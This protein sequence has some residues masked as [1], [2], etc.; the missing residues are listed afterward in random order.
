MTAHTSLGTALVTGA[1]SGIGAVYADRLARRGYQL[2]LV[3]RDQAR[4]EALAERLR[5]QTGAQVEVLAA[6]LNTPAEL[7]RVE[8]RLREDSSI[9][10]LVNNAGVASI[11]P[12]VSSNID[13]VDQMLQLNVVA[14][15]RLAAAALA[16]FVP[17]GKGILVNIGSVVSLAPE[18]FNASYAASKAYVL[19][20]SQSLQAEAGPS[21]VQVHAVL[22]GATRTEIWDRAGFSVDQL[23]AAMVMDTDALVDAALLGMDRQERVTIP[24]LPDAADWDAFLA[25][26]AVLGPNLS[27]NQPAPRFRA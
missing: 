19:S 23:P 27:H 25:A 15:T 11:G 24:S 2:V 4:L 9:T 7:A 1:S 22:P 17:R 5:S 6:D 8:Q 10:L 12:L 14:L 26:R 20:L 16:G 3:A 13:S 18:T 21:G